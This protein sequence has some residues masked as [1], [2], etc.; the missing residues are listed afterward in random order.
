LNKV[1]KKRFNILIIFILILMF[2]LSFGLF[3]VQIIKNDYYNEKVLEAST[4]IT[5]GDSSPRG[6]IYDRNGKL[7]VDNEAVKVIYYKKQSGDKPLDEIKKSYEIAKIIEVDYKNLTKKMLKDFY[8]IQNNDF[9]SKKITEEEIEKLERREISNNDIYN[10]KLERISDEE[11]SIYNDL[12]KEAAYI[13]YLINKGYSYTNKVIK[14]VGVT[15]YEY[16]LVGEMIDSIKGLNV[17]LD[18]VRKYLYGDV[19]K[20]ILGSVSTTETGL[21]YEHKDYY[22]N[23]G[24]NLNDRVGLNGIEYQYESILKGVKDKY[25]IVDGYYKLLESGKRGNDIYLTIDIELQKKVEEILTNQLY[26]AKKYENTEHYNK[27]FIVINDPNTGEVLAMSGKQIKKENGKYVIYD[28]TPGVI[29]TPITVGSVVKGASHIVGYNTGALK[30]GEVRYDTCIKIASTPSKCSYTNMGYIN[31]IEALQKSSNV[32]QFLTAI[33]VGGGIYRY[34]KALNLNIEAFDIYRNTFKQFGLGTYTQI[35]LPNEALGYVGSST[36]PGYLLDFSIGQYDSYTSIQLAQY[37]STI[38]NGGNRMKF[39]LLKSVYDYENL[40]YEVEPT[41]LNKVETKEEYIK[42]VQL[43]FRKVITNGTGYSH[44]TQ[45]YNFAGKTGTS[46]SFA[47]TNNDGVIDTQTYTK[48]F[49]GYAPYDNP[50]VAFVITSPDVSTGSYKAPITRLL[51][52]KITDLY[53]KMYK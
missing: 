15:D 41:I 23:L 19:F 4:I 35:D 45:K 7:I 9:V 21:P 14:K 18:W 51:T 52:K 17:K 50:K 26:D 10:Y 43:G 28:Y 34:N 33:N 39:N 25:Q 8:I 53:F 24:Y 13:Y 40:V 6:R 27:S 22:L 20:S 16:A 1:I 42:R 46:E 5:Y 36:L 49:I 48:T 31:D 30:I 47:D 38:A 12:D 32:Y 2:I 29:T 11:L 3:F 44:V 37:I